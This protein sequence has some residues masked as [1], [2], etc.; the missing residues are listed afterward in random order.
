[1]GTFGVINNL[2]KLAKQRNNNPPYIGIKY[3][4]PPFI[5]KNEREFNI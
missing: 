3:Q 1:V 4:K 5:F 2:K